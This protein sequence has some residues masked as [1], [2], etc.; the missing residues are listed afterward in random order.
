MHNAILVMAKGQFNEQK[1]VLLV[2]EKVVFKVLLRKTAIL[3]MVKGQKVQPAPR[4]QESDIK[5][6]PTLIIVVNV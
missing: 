4:V 3:V 1:D 6:S 5:T 2:T